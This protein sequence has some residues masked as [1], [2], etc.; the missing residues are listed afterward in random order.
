MLSLQP[1]EIINTEL[2]K[3]TPLKTN[4]PVNNKVEKAVV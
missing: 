3:S 1:N 4:L 2:K